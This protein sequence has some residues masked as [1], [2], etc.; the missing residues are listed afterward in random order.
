MALPICHTA[1]NAT[2]DASPKATVGGLYTHGGNIYRY[3]QAEDQAWVAGYA[4]QFTDTFGE[5]TTDVS[6]GSASGGAAGIAQYA[7]TDAYYGYVLVKGYATGLLTN[8]SVAA[9]DILWG[10]SADGT[11]IPLAL[12]GASLNLA[13]AA[14]KKGIFGVADKADSGTAGTGFIDCI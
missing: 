11:L 2:N 7:V 5:A 6:G 8:G 4:L 10:G 3:M 12:S 14:L 1:P 13:N 9:G